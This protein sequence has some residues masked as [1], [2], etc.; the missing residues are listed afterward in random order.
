MIVF[1]AKCKINW[2]K[3]WSHDVDDSTYE[4]CP[5]CNTDQH[6]E[7]GNDLLAFIKCPFTGEIKNVD[8]GMVIHVQQEAA[9]P[10][11]KRKVKVFD[12]TWEEFED[13]REQL[14]NEYIEAYQRNY[15][16]MG[17]EQAS[18]NTP[19]PVIQRKYHFE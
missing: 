2:A 7:P 8:N 6:I 10:P 12:E 19:Y 14:Q 1:C 9:A 13:R 5:V 3:L 11:F 16:S 15:Q 17:H 4:F 18:K